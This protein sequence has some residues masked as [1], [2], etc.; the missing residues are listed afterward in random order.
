LRLEFGFPRATPIAIAAARVTEHQ[1]AAGVGVAAAAFVVPPARDG[2]RGK[3]RRVVRDADGD[4]A[5][6]G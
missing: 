1:Q 5:T 2:A 6:I 4:A 3:G